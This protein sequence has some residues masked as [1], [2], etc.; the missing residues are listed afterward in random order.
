MTYENKSREELE[1]ENCAPEWSKEI[2][3][4]I[5]QWCMEDDSNRLSTADH[6]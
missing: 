2:R 5:W 6:K 4:A 3:D 1:T